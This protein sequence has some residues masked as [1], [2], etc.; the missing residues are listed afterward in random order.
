MLDL[1]KQFF[2]FSIVGVLSFGVDY[3]LLF[4]LTEWGNMH[5][6]LSAGCSF[7]AATGFNYIYSKKYVFSL[8]EDISRTGQFFIFLLLA[9]LGLVLNMLL[10]HWGVERLAFHY[11]GAKVMATL[12]VSIWN[13]FTRKLFLEERQWT[14]HFKI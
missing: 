8:R 12:L 2:R 10:M 11:M 1:W 3:G 7:A 6:L 9:L 5:Y 13:F 4:L 14:G